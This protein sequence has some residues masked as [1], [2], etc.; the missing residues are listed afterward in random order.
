M[1][2]EIKIDLTDELRGIY[3]AA[4]DFRANVEKAG[5][6]Y[7]AICAPLETAPP[8]ELGRADWYEFQIIADDK[9]RAIEAAREKLTALFGA[10]FADSYRLH[11]S[12]TI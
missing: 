2:N 6:K 11:V 10:D 5:K 7:T 1:S 12:E 4:A 3:K 8:G 9:P